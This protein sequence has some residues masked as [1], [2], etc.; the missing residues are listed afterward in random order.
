MYQ[1][2]NYYY[3]HLVFSEVLSRNHTDTINYFGYCSLTD[4]IDFRQEEKNSVIPVSA[5]S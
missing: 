1:L 2:K 5:Y 4:F 3:F